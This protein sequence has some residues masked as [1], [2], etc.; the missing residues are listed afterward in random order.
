MDVKPYFRYWG[1]AK[2]GLDEA[3][4][5]WH[6][7]PFHSLDV[8]AV[9]SVWWDE[10]PAIQHSFMQHG[11]KLSTKQMK[12]WVIFFIALHDYGKFDIRFQRKASRVWEAL[13]PNLAKNVARMPTI[14]ACKGYDHG[15]AGLY[16]F[17]QDR[18]EEDSASELDWM[19]HIVDLVNVVDDA[20]Q[21]WMAWIKPVTG[22]HG[23]VYALDH[24]TPERSLHSTVDKPIAQQDKTARL[25]W[26]DELERLFLKPVG[27]SLQDTPPTPSPLL[28]GFCSV[29]DWLGSRS[30]EVNFC[31]KADPVDDLRDYFDQKCRED[32]QRVLVLA[33]IN[34][35]AKPFLGVQALLKRDYQPR[36]L[37]TL[38]DDL[39][40]TPGLTIV[41]APTGSGK[42]EMA[43]AY[44]WR[45]LAANH[46]DSIVFAM[47]T[48]A[49]A[50]AMLQRLEKIATTLFEDKPNL[51][52]AHGH[53]RFNDNFLKLKQIGKT[54][55]ENEEAWVQCNEWLGQSRKRIF[56]GQ[57][58]IC[59]VDQVLV[60]VLPV[61][62]RFVRGFGVGRSVLIVDEVHAYDAYMYGLLEAVLKAQHEV[63]GSSIL[64][65]ATLP[66]SLKNQLLAT[67]GKAIETAQTHAPYPL[68][69]WS[70]GKAN[71]AFTLPDNEQPPL[72]QVQVECHESEDLLPDAAL[73]QRIIDAAEQ[74]AQVAIICNLVDVAQQ[75][76]RDL[77]KLTALPVDIFHARYCLHDRQKKEDTVLKHYGAE[78]KRASGRILVA[79][80]VIEQSLDVDFDW[81][82]TQL[83][84][85]DLLFQRMG[86]LHRHE[87][88][89][90]TGFE[91]ARCTVLLPMGNDYGTHGLIYRNT[92]VMW[93]TAQK[94]QTCPDQII[95][96]PAAY[97][98]WIEPIYS[99]EA[100]GT[101][102]EVIETGFAL[103]EEKLAEKRIL[104][105]QMLKW[106]EDVA[107]MDDDENVRAV[108]RDG[109]FNV[110]VIP[111]LD[112]ARG[113]Q[114]LDS[115]ILDSLSEWQQ[116]EALAM[117]I[118][119]VPK[120]WGKLLP[121]KDKEGRVWLAMQQGGEFWK[122]CSKEIWFTY[123]PVW[124]MEKTV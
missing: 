39:P 40:V 55:Q 119:G 14:E 16:W 84:P 38:V 71:H 28:A 93:R 117:N 58:G 8:A 68:I 98:D 97:R 102:P 19:L 43:L 26:L 107:L 9:A 80:Q 83:C 30:D 104:A 59:T 73:R 66:Q 76:A 2:P 36:Q 124:G 89:R 42:T 91:S 48:Q 110:S 3:E 17:E 34:G 18:V 121:E 69:S 87:R 56:L 37:Q 79:T 6:L 74:G 86:R 118:V 49:T 120:S 53:A 32:A 41:E 113:K 27:L 35:K 25:A 29:A 115:S 95:D 54:V 22:H 52:L 114:L 1:K 78:G 13:Q 65:S 88:S 90:P 10:S 47:P 75:L 122:A 96:F 81:L 108:T 45:L 31:Y 94:L 64:L 92:R 15:S 105:R 103:F 100:W 33:G 44:A 109:E 5:Q 50:N 82:I 62:H 7:L 60:S 23:F 111:Y 77:Q 112:T 123:H 85:V 101:E 21:T 67:S 20:Q 4:A 106:A 57:I 12:A 24:P 51:I 116:A 99:E 46:A 61:K 72:R 70:D 63:G 11:G